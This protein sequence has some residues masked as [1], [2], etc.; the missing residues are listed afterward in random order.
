M[1][2]T[3]NDWNDEKRSARLYLVRIHLKLS[4]APANVIFCV[5]QMIPFEFLRAAS[6]G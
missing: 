6:I 2:E 4:Q 1:A 5:L 3:M